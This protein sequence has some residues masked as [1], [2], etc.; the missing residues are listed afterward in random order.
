M[1]LQW[2]PQDIS[3]YGPQIDSAIKLIF[4]TVGISLVLA[5]G[6]LIAFALM[7]RRKPGR[8]AYFNRGET[9]RELAWVLV[10]ALIVLALDLGIDVAGA[11]SWDIVKEAAPKPDLTV[12]VTAMRYGWNF[13]YPGPDGVFGTAD[14]IQQAFA[15]QVPAGKVVRLILTSQDVIH[16]FYVPELRLKQDVVPGREITAWFEATRPGNYEIV[17]SQLCGPLH[18]AMKGALGV[19]TQEAFRDWMDHQVAANAP[20]GAKPA[21]KIES[22]KPGKEG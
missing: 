7:Y 14:D 19:Q 15:L 6:T 16:S 9:G 21:N 8:R 1:D 5:E 3:T 12:R 11:R 10:P 2:L 17:C 20:H 13:T 18:F 22:S 4:Y